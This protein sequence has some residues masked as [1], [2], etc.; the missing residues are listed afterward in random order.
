MNREAVRAFERVVECA[1]RGQRK[2][3]VVALED[4]LISWKVPKRRPPRWFR[5]GAKV[6]SRVWRPGR[7]MTVTYMRYDR[8]IGEHRFTVVDFTDLND[9]FTFSGT[10]TGYESRFP[11][12]R[13][14]ASST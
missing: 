6:E 12:R 9:K 3:L 7:V 4:A 13:A 8:T 11:F 5:K 10:I 2:K 1:R 14:R